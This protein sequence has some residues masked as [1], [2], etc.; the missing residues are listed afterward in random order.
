[1]PFVGI[2]SIN[3]YINA[4]PDERFAITQLQELLTYLSQYGVSSFIV[5]GQVGVIRP[6]DAPLNTSS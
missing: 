5:V 3:G 1:M 4:L 2:D 6:A